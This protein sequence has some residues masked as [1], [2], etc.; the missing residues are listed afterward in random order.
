MKGM[1]NRIQ[2]LIDLRK[3]FIN[4]RK[5]YRPL[6]H[7]IKTKDNHKITLIDVIRKF[8]IGSMQVLCFCFRSIS[9]CDE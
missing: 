2:E 4:Y 3:G 9:E 7:I 5:Q 8:S 1:N 6:Q